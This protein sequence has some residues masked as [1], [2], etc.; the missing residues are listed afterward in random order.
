MILTLQHW[1]PLALITLT[2]KL[3]ALTDMILGI[4]CQD[5]FKS[6][7]LRNETSYILVHS[8]CISHQFN[9]IENMFLKLTKAL[10]HTYI[11]YGQVKNKCLC[12]SSYSLH[13]A[14][15]EG[16]YTPCLCKLSIGSSPLHIKGQ[17]TP[18]PMHVNYFAIYWL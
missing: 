5:I 8:R 10:S 9:G 3:L 4:A 1:S 12:V 14:H 15:L 6:V 7:L 17:T 16:S 11:M 13:K 18:I 2:I